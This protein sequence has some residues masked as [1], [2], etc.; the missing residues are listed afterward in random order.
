MNVNTASPSILMSV[1]VLLSL[2]SSFDV[3]SS[4]VSASSAAHHVTQ[5]RASRLRR[6]PAMDLQATRQLPY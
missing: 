4:T 3:S 1:I 2:M 5:L 6:R